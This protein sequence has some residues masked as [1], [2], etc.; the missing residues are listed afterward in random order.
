[1][2]LKPF[3]GK[4]VVIQLREPYM[5]VEHKGDKVELLLLKSS[6]G[7]NPAPIQMPIL[8][9]KVVETPFGACLEYKDPN[10]KPILVQVNPDAV[11]AVSL[12]GEDKKLIDIL[13]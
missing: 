6:A 2:D 10:Q 8:Q 11:L 5:L 7:G 3:A 13:S 1:M 9:G 12:A 4:F